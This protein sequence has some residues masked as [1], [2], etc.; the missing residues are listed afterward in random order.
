MALPFSEPGIVTQVLY[1]ESFVVLMRHD[2]PLSKKD[3]IKASELKAEELLLLGEGH[4]F[5]RQV[6]EACPNCYSD[7][8]SLQKS[9]EGTSLETLRHMVASGMGVTVL[10]SSAT[11]IQFYK[12]ILCTRPF[13]GKV[14]QRRIALAWRMSFTRP[15]AISA[16]IQALQA[17]QMHGICLI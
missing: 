17:S 14:P 12:S 11:Q 1:D 7:K 9:V 13:A 5:R 8:V 2:H 15:K 6:L 4:C 10:P 16:L 3:S